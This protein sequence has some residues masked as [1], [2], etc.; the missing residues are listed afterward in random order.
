MRNGG[1]PRRFLLATGNAHKAAEIRELLG[2]VPAELLSLADLQLDLDVAEDGETYEA[3]ALAKARAAARLSGLPAIA[4]DSGIEVDALEGTP[5]IR[6]ARFAGEDATDHRNNELLLNLLRDVPEGRRGARFVCAAVLVEPGEGGREVRFRGEWQ[7]R[8]AFE[9][10]GE[11]GFGYD[12]V[13][14]IPEEGRTVAELGTAYKRAH[15]HRSRAFRQIAAHLK[16]L[17][18]GGD[19]L[20]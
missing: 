20:D 10:A 12:P 1:T 14:L 7:G 4:D 16:D 8:I 5:G 19:S 17:A 18:A 6:S 11:T 13:F 3:N 2:D 15:S 9:P